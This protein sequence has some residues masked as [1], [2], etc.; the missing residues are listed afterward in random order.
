[1]TALDFLDPY[2]LEFYRQ[3]NYFSFFSEKFIKY[4]KKW[5]FMTPKIQVNKSGEKLKKSSNLDFYLLLNFILRN[6]KNKW[7]QTQNKDQVFKMDFSH[8]FLRSETP[9]KK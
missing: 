8:W 6:T 4:C 9:I 2:F 7:I 3:K 1:M 5:N